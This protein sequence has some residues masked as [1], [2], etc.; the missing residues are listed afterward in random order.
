MPSHLSTPYVAKD[1]RPKCLH[2]GVSY[3]IIPP[4]VT[5]VQTVDF[6]LTEG[7]ITLSALASNSS[8][9]SLGPIVPVDNVA[10]LGLR[11]RA[12]CR[13]ARSLSA[14][15]HGERHLCTE[16]RPFPILQRC[17]HH[18]TL[19]PVRREA[20]FRSAADCRSYYLNLS[21]DSD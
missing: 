21:G 4:F 11:R 7:M 3:K 13:N 6:N 14:T 8:N 2:C 15:D 17:C 16:A 10:L 12:F 19:F 18:Q 20:D 5:P 1:Y 9:R